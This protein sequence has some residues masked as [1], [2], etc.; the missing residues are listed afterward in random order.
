MMNDLTELLRMR[1][2]ALDNELQETR[3]RLIDKDRELNRAIYKLNE[4]RNEK[5]LYS[6]N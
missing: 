1:V 5:K 4:L 2:E 3:V 6:L